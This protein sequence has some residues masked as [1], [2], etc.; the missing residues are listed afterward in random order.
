MELRERL[1]ELGFSGFECSQMMMAV[2]LEM[3]G[4]DNPDLIRAMSGLTGG[5]GHSGGV[6]GALTGGCC[7]LGLLTGKGDPEEMEH[8]D[9]RKILQSYIAWFE[10][11]WGNRF[12][13]S[14][15]RDIV[16]GDFSKCMTVCLPV[17]ESCCEKIMELAEEYELMG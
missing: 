14:L 13:S 5:M 1:M 16:G 15:C 4:Q 11:S 12:G 7:V 2:A 10:E 6:C 8:N 9:S 17:I 3:D